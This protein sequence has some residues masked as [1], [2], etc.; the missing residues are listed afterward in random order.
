M[1]LETELLSAIPQSIT[2]DRL[3]FQQILMNLLDNA[4]K[5]TEQGRIRLTAQTID[6]PGSDRSLRFEVSD[7]GI[8]MT[9]EEISGLFQPFY[10]VRSAAPGG[11][12]G[13]GLGL[14]ICKILAKRLGGEITV[15]STPK[16]GTTF[17]LTIP[18][19]LPEDVAQFQEPSRL[20]LELRFLTP[21]DQIA[22]RYSLG[23]DCRSCLAST[24][25]P[26]G[27]SIF[28]ASSFSSRCSAS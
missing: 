5:F 24:F 4:I 8:G 16:V 27:V 14:A 7:T 12:A 2:T 15:W 19:D 3:R 22:A 20:L 26:V 28:S 10:R 23:C 17:T 25:R 9:A 6:R 13:T 21:P 1:R 18:A 11:P